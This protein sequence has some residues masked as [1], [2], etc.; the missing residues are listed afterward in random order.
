MPADMS[1]ALRESVEGGE[2]ASTSEAIRD[3]IRVWRRQRAEDANR[4]AVIRARIRRSLDDP[5]ANMTLAEIDAQV[6]A[7]FARA[8]AEEERPNATPRG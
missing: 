8:K 1:A 5:R 3:A 7:L 6:D 4:L 2:Y